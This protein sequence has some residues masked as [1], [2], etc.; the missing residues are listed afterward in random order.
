MLLALVMLVPAARAWGGVLAAPVFMSPPTPAN[1]QLY[2]ISQGQALTFT[3]RALDTDAN[4]VVTLQAQGVPAGASLT[5]ALPTSGNFVESTFSWTPTAAEAGTYAMTFTARDQQN[6]QVTTTVSVRVT[7]QPC[8]PVANQPQANPDRLSTAMATP[9]VFTAAQLLANDTDPQ[10][11]ALQVSRVHLPSSGN[12]TSNANGSYTYTPEAAFTGLVTFRYLIEPAGVLASEASGHYYELVSAP[13][14]CW[15]AA[16][17]AAAARTYLG[18]RGYLATVTSPAEMSVLA[19]RSTGQY[20]LGAA[21]DLVEGEW[22]WKTGPEAGQLFWQGAVNG[23]AVGYANWSTNE[24]NNSI[25]ATRPNGENY[26][27]YYGASGLWNDVSECNASSTT[28]GYVVEYGGLEPC[29]PVRFATGTV[30]IAVGQATGTAGSTAALVP[31]RLEAFPNPSSGELQVRMVAAESGPAQL[32]LYDLQGR[33]LQPAF[34][35]TLSAGIPHTVRLGLHDVASGL[36]LL[37]LQSGRQVQHL[38]VQV[39]R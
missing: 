23:S 15:Q 3:V 21:D 25:S 28:A 20:W 19:G 17:S 35:G 6:A 11:Q 16:S 38:R 18:L 24:P 5:P 12:I 37:R 29:T 1:G 8:N 13:G 4:D 27:L 2:Q 9:L 10:G 34:S 36:Y 39:L 22:R 7:A 26:L 31:N 30:T 32:H 14:I 33:Q